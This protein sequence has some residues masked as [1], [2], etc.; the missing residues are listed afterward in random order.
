MIFAREKKK[1]E[2]VY[3]QDILYTSPY[4]VALV[5]DWHADREEHSLCTLLY[6]NTRLLYIIVRTEC[7]CFVLLLFVEHIR[8]LN[9]KMNKNVTIT[10]AAAIILGVF[11]EMQYHHPA[12]ATSTYAQDLAHRISLLEDEEEDEEEEPEEEDGNASSS[13]FNIA[14]V[15]D[16]GCDSATEDTVD[17]I[18]SKSP[19]VVIGLG[20]NAYEDYVDCWFDIVEPI[21]DIMKN[22]IGNHDIEDG[23]LDE[24]L[25]HYDDDYQSEQ[26]Y[27]F[28]HE[29]VQI[30]VM[31]T[32][33]D[34]SADSAQHS[35]VESE[36][37]DAAADSSVDWIII[38]MHRQMYASP[39][40]ALGH[41][42]L[43]LREA[44]H[45]LFQKY[46]VDLV[47]YGHNHYYER[48]YPLNFTS[49]EENDD[50]DDDDTDEPFITTRE[51]TNYLSPDGQIFITIG[52]GGQRI[53][54]FTDRKPYVVSQFDEGYG[55][56]D[57]TITDGGKRLVGL[58]Y[59]NDDD[60]DGSIQ[61]QFTVI[62]GG[63]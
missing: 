2:V 29:N 42:E 22:V 48:T 6:Y 17:N 28:S 26:Y 31:S 37:E 49:N 9:N 47:L 59:E 63:R 25:E 45:P 34:Y 51:A 24:I 60:D 1:E 21:D 32:E 19:E 40:D 46:G 16:W 23:H 12:A 7:H 43:D 10:I 57:I 54:E 44:Y 33:V 61:D 4:P 39:T 30:I 53:F 13:D 36:L 58:F 27:A 35:F 38:A 50:D 14:A 11:P 18:I 52:T 5:M 8:E 3:L 15:G 55:F 20:D 41:E 62:K 56:L